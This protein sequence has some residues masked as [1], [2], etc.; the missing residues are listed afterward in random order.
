MRSQRPALPLL[1]D[2][3]L[4]DEPLQGGPQQIESGST[5]QSHD[6]LEDCRR[7]LQQVPNRCAGLRNKA[8][9][10]EQEHPSGTGIVNDRKGYG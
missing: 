2:G 8:L 6:R 3:I 9:A 4:A 10:T 5:G 1:V 7:S